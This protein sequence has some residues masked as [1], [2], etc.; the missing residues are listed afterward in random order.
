MCFTVSGRNR[1][2]AIRYA[3][4]GAKVDILDF[5]LSPAHGS[6]LETLFD[7]L[8]ALSPSTML[9]AESS[10]VEGQSTQRGQHLFLSV[11]FKHFIIFL[12]ALCA[13]VRD[14]LFLSSLGYFV[15]L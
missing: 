5:C 12:C 8:T 14:H 10:R 1:E 7:T 4:W 13:S 6:S 15:L 11:L 9:R 2:R 3:E